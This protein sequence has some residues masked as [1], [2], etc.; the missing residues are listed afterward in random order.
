MTYTYAANLYLLVQNKQICTRSTKLTSSL[1]IQ[2]ISPKTYIHQ[3]I[4]SRVDP[5][6]SET[7]WAWC[8]LKTGKRCPYKYQCWCK[9]WCCIGLVYTTLDGSNPQ[10]S[11]ISLQLI[12]IIDHPFSPISMSP[13][14]HC[15]MKFQKG[16]KFLCRRNFQLYA[17]IKKF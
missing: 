3:D 7:L 11:F 9:K 10:N 13:R 6:I 14:L 2:G 17:Q 16:V 15:K 5:V 4:H 12:T 8:N 1:S